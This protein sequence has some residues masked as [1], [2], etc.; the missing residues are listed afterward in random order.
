[1]Q[2]KSPHGPADPIGI[3][4]DDVEDDNKKRRMWT[5]TQRSGGDVPFSDG[6]AYNNAIVAA[7]WHAMK[8]NINIWQKASPP[9]VLFGTIN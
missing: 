2:M 1:M 9:K 8:Q 7:I 3:G 4:Q 6:F 5:K